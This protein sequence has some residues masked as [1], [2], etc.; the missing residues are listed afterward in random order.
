MEVSPKPETL[1][2]T[3]VLANYL[4]ASLTA[5]EREGIQS[6]V[7]TDGLTVLTLPPS[8]N[9]VPVRQA[10]PSLY[11]H[12]FLA[13]VPDGPKR[14]HLTYNGKEI[15]EVNVLKPGLQS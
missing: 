13:S 9:W 4:L 3:E 14:I 15:V 12:A 2:L 11:R 8:Y 1:V 6:S 10:S 7:N 5:E